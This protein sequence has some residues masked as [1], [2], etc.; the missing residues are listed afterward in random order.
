MKKKTRF[1]KLKVTGIIIAILGITIVLVD[2]S[3]SSAKYSKGD[4]QMKRIENSP[5]YKDGKFKNPAAWKQPSF[6]E[7][8]S[9]LRDF[10]F[11]G[12]HRT[13][14]KSPPIINV[15]L[16]GF[17]NPG[18]NQLNVTW[19][20]HSSLMINIDG[21][22]I[23][24]DPVFQERISILGP[25]RYNGKV[26]LDLNRLPPIDT[27]IISHNHYDHL[28][29]FSIQFLSQKAETF[30]VPLG[31]GAQL[32]AWDV[33]RKKIVEL[34]WWDEFQVDE[35]LMIAAAP[36]QHFSGRSL[37][38]RDQTL[39]VSWV[40][41]GPHHKIYFSGDSGYFDGFKQIGDK[42]GP[43]D[44]TF[45]E[46]GAYNEKWHHIHMFPEETVQA[47]IDLK[48]KVLHPIHWATFNL[49]LHS[50]NEPMKRLTA[51]VD[52]SNVKTATPLVGDTTVYN[53]YIPSEK[54]WEQGVGDPTLFTVSLMSF[55][56]GRH[57][58]S[59]FFCM[60]L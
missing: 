29:K 30:F 20:G 8:A 52:L 53:A 54:W 22:K 10:L 50:W 44:M 41:K 55:F 45:I 37:S 40:I 28:N 38:D 6:G 14:K 25:S 43:F 51:A 16:T 46:C 17:N 2:H 47:H 26:P 12:D 31:V 59:L 32:E 24:I 7:Y 60:L 57:L 21:Y 23:L 48:G 36:A 5:Q 49:S 19:L 58:K 35:N 4:I 3:F 39:W 11:G 56:R 27:V 1:K 18:N 34:D 15:D 9:T 33:H 42:Y 13:P